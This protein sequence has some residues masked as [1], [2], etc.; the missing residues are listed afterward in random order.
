[1]ANFIERQEHKVE[2]LPPYSI[3]QCRVAEIV[4]KEDGGVITELGRNYI[5]YVR[6]PG[7]DVSQDCEEVRK[8]AEVLWTPELIEQYQASLAEVP[9]SLPE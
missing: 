5:R 8:V 6:Y 4:E 7:D 3:I 2:I 1:M 9:Q